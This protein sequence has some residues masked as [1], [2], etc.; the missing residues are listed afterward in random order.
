MINQFAQAADDVNRFADSAGEG[1]VGA[2]IVFL[3]VG[4][5]LIL[6]SFAFTIWM[7]VD[8]AMKPVNNKTLWIVLLIL[9]LLFGFGLIPAIIYYFT[10]RKNVQLP[11]AAGPQ[12]QQQ[13]Q[14][15]VP[16]V[17]ANSTW[18][19]TSPTANTDAP[20]PTDTPPSVDGA[21][22]DNAPAASGSADTPTSD[23]RPDQP[24]Q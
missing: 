1:A 3:L 2:T 21:R 10:D 9:G 4:I 6:A 16:P 14:S 5:L 23:S 11:G 18:P 12:A 19:T 7:L 13:W 8:A 15:Q 17:D 24:R 22:S 20:N